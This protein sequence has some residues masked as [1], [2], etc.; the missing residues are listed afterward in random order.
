M[1]SKR[2]FSFS[3][4]HVRATITTRLSTKA[5]RAVSKEPARLEVIL[6]S[7]TLMASSCCGAGDGESAACSSVWRM[8]ITVPAKPRM[9]MAYRNSRTGV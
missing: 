1:A 9:G 8:L 5:S 7:A 6:V 3:T 4:T 2:L